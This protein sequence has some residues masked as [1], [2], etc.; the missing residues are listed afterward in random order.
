MLQFLKVNKQLSEAIQE[1]IQLQSKDFFNFQKV[2]PLSNSNCALF[3]FSAY[4]SVL[5][6]ELVFKGGIVNWR[7]NMGP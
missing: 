4:I 3:E 2:W 6:L 5:F 7:M 1:Y